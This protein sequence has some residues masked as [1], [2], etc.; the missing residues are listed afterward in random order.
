[1]QQ[2]VER[3]VADA[4]AAA[5]D[6]RVEKVAFDQGLDSVVVPQDI[7]VV[8]TTKPPNREACEG[9]GSCRALSACSG[10][11]GLAHDD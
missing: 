2:L 5:E 11:R 8:G 7:D 3:V 9:F 6:P 4:G 1:M 10:A